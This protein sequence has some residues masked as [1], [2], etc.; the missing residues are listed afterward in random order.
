[1]THGVEAG[2]GGT[3]SKEVAWKVLVEEKKS[4][5]DQGATPIKAN[6]MRHMMFNLNSFMEMKMMREMGAGLSKDDIDQ[7]ETPVRKAYQ[8]AKAE[9]MIT[10]MKE[11]AAKRSCLAFA[12]ASSSTSSPLQRQTGSNT[13]SNTTTANTTA[14][15]SDDENSE[16]DLGQCKK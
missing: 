8:K 11:M 13:T 5:V 7:L 3:S 16:V 4:N 15:N 12:E 9:L 2:Q 14:N 10:Q 1:M 6:D